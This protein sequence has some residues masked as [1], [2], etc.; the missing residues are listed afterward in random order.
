M[1]TRE[2]SSAQAILPYQLRA[3]DYELSPR[4]QAAEMNHNQLGTLF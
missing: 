1:P 3:L 4:L 2:L